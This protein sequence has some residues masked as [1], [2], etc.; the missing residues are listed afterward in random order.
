M[1]EPNLNFKQTV[2]PKVIQRTILVG[3]VKAAQALKMPESE[4]AKLLADVEKDPLFQD[5]L[6]ARDEGRRIIKFKRFGSTSLSGQFYDQQDVNVAGSTGQS[7]E[8][9]LDQK[10]H[11]LKIIQKIGQ[12]KFEKHFLYRE[13]S[14]DP[15]EIARICELSLEETKQLQ[16]FIINMSVEAEFYHPSS[17]DAGQKVKPTLV[18][19]IIQNEDK[20][21]SIS[22]FSPHLARGLYEIDHNA[23][24]RW[25]KNKKL[26]RQA[27]ARL[28]KFVGV[29]ELSNLKEGAFWRVIDFLL[30]AQ[31][32]F[33]ETKDVSKLAPVS[34]RKVAAKLQFAPSTISRVMS[35]K[36]VLLPWDHEVMITYLMPG[37]RRVVLSI[38]EKMTSEGLTNATD[39][40]VAA[41]IE[42]K[43]GIKISRRTVT[44]CR[45]LLNTHEEKAA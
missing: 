4:W 27:A 11:L 43:F 40:A 25:Q 2:S 13:E 23:L 31:K 29:L 36:S 33:F 17:L 21:F 9:L 7:P 15:Q 14:N 19:R 8:A 44:A 20:T 16:D 38:M 32:D 12:E 35:T 42:E 37:Q 18:G 26:D 41:R 45:H 30:K 22:F 10:K 6:T 1:A 24:R 5:L 39:K 28:K 3:R 34:L